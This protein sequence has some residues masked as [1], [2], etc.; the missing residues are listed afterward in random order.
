[1][2]VLKGEKHKKV[3]CWNVYYVADIPEFLYGIVKESKKL[4]SI[5]H[6]GLK[7]LEV[8][9][10]TLDFML[11]Q[12]DKHNIPVSFH[13]EDLPIPELV[14]F[15][16]DKEYKYQEDAAEVLST[17]NNAL[18]QFGVGSGKTRISLL[19]LEKRFKLNTN[20]RV[21]V[22]TGLAALQQNWLDDS[23][24]FNLC[25]GKF[26][27]T[28]IGN[29]KE[30]LTLISQAGDGD[31]LTANFGML[32]NLDLLKSFVDFNPDIVIFDE[33][34]MIANMGN[35][36]V[37]GAMRTEGLHELQ[38]DHWSLSASPVKFSPFD[39]RSLLIW[40]RAL[41]PDMSQSAFEEYYG[42]FGFNYMGQ[43]VCESYKD[44][45]GLLPFVNSVRLAFK[46]TE[47]PELK[48]ID[49]PVADGDKKSQYNVR[50]Y[51]N[52]VNKHKIEYIKNLGKGCIVAS[53]IT[54]P[55]A[56]WKDA[57]SDLRVSVFDGTLTLKE[58]KVVISRCI[59]QEVDVL[60]LSLSAGGVGL[61]LAEAYSDMAFI[62]CPNSL[63]DFWQGYGRV[64]RIGAKYPVTVHKIYCKGTSDEYRWKQIYADFQALRIFY[65]F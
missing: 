44:L 27:I 42:N 37:S 38:G 46:G 59:N 9:K 64:Y 15:E 30:S 3:P 60:L 47:L 51:N 65:E 4:T 6:R 8:D 50:Q 17:M 14:V 16:D 34:H 26:T 36:R 56:V 13:G 2:R 10:K 21:L 43:R 5:Y 31:I 49:A 12:C 25:K 41:S 55:F 33:V 35:K 61:N 58:R 57:L 22:V 54:K 63:V 24:K 19:A 39:W 29:S 1:M 45:S 20:L 28:G 23:E 11:A 53:N 62:D 40:L 7:L 18:L 48:F 32:S 52:C